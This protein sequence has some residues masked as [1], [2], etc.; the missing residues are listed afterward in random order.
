MQPGE[1]RTKTKQK[2]DLIYFHVYLLNYEITEY[3]SNVFDNIFLLSFKNIDLG[4]F[5]EKC[6]RSHPR[7]A[8]LG[9]RL[10]IPGMN[11][12]HIHST[13]TH[14]FLYVSIEYRVSIYLLHK[15]ASFNLADSKAINI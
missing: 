11:N 8:A 7:D 13:Y 5:G 1:N 2:F 3:S 10:A 9:L 15:S 6:W 4:P 12:I 14:P